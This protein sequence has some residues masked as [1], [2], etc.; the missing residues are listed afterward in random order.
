MVIENLLVFSGTGKTLSLLCSTLAWIEHEKFNDSKS[1]NYIDTPTTS[2]EI[3]IDPKETPLVIYTARTHTQIKQGI[4]SLHHCNLQLNYLIYLQKRKFN[5][6][7]Y[8]D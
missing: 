8:F 7:I 4:N 6:S 2:M 3:D 5:Y 1:D